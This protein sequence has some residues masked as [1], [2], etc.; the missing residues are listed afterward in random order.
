[1]L[2]KI[3]CFAVLILLL[4]LFP[5][6][7]SIALWGLITLAYINCLLLLGLFAVACVVVYFFLP[8]R[9]Y[10]VLPKSLPRND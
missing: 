1:M 3:I 8:R 7:R 9:T 4:L 10:H 6:T 2:P 5:V